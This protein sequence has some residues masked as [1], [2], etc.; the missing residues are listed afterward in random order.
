[1]KPKRKS[2]KKLLITLLVLVLVGGGVFAYMYMVRD[3]RTIITTDPNTTEYGGTSDSSSTDNEPKQ[4]KTADDGTPLSDEPDP[5]PATNKSVTITAQYYNPD[6]AK[7]V[8]K[9]TVKNI[10]SGTCKVTFSKSGQKDVTKT[11]AVE[12]VT[13]YYACGSLN[14]DRAKFPKSGTWSLKVQVIQEGV[15]S[16]TSDT[17]T[18]TIQ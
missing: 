18:I 3:T 16:A 1:M 7:A 4:P 17:K 12:V 14:T 2:S 10:K 13:S 11:A 8:V 5:T 9:A 15:V 6:T